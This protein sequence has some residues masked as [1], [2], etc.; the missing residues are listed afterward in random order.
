MALN[1]QGNH[2]ATCMPRMTR[3]GHLGYHLPTIP[4]NFVVT[5][6]NHFPRAQGL[7]DFTLTLISLPLR[8]TATFYTELIE[9]I[10]WCYVPHA[11][12][13]W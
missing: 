9:L 4:H 7:V 13:G 8:L 10:Y 12:E 1:P 3:N 2:C 11:P 6:K 5:P